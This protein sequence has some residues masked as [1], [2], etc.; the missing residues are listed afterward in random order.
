MTLKLLSLFALSL[1][2]ATTGCAL[3]TSETEEDDETSELAED[4]EAEDEIAGD[5]GPTEPQTS[6]T[7]HQ[8]NIKFGDISP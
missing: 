4:E 7:R 3:E 8:A 6:P 2:L 1:L 5:A